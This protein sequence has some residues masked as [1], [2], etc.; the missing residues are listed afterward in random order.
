MPCDRHQPIVV[1]DVTLLPFKFSSCQL[2]VG[3]VIAVVGDGGAA[4]HDVSFSSSFDKYFRQ[5]I[6]STDYCLGCIRRAHTF[7]TVSGTVHIN[8]L[9]PV[10]VVWVRCFVL[11][12]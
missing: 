1:L 4:T 9:V 6:I 11:Q 2:L 5:S 8:V 12:I 3:H 7:C 10:T